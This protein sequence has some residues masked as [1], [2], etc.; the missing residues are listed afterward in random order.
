MKKFNLVVIVVMVSIFMFPIQGNALN[1]MESFFLKITVIENGVEHEWEYT[2]P[3]KYEYEKGNHVIKTLE[4]KEQMLSIVKT[5]NL[6]ETAKV[7]EM[8]EDLKKEKFPKLEQLDI[9]W[10][11]KESKLY[12]WVWNSKE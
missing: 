4:A 3:G 12:T 2:S 9:R 8:V 6:S 1:L 10:M 5:L 7:E 11:N